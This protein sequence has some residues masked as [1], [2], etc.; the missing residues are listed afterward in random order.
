MTFQPKP[1]ARAMTPSL[2]LRPR[3]VVMAPERLAGRLAAHA[4]EA[5][6]TPGL[7]RRMVHP[8]MG[9]LQSDPGRRLGH[10]CQPGLLRGHGVARLGP[11]VMADGREGEARPTGVGE[12]LGL[13]G[14]RQKSDFAPLNR[15]LTACFALRR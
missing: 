14:D 15:S 5:V 13:G 1:R 11:R 6:D 10:A 3:R 2:W 8:V 12:E 9:L 4:G 7:A